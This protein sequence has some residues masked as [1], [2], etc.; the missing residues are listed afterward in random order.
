MIQCTRNKQ[1][2]F[3][4][5]VTFVRENIKKNVISTSYVK[6]EEQLIDIFMK[7][8]NRS[9]VEYSYDMLGMIMVR[10]G[11]GTKIVYTSLFGIK[12]CNVV[13]YLVKD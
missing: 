12:D 9:R 1:N 13:S 6:I 11:V 2:T 5:T 7:D 10:I 8:L 3:R 4:L